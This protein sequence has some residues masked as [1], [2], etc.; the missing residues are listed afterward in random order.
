MMGHGNVKW[1]RDIN[2][3]VIEE[4]VKSS[5]IQGGLS[6]GGCKNDWINFWGFWNFLQSAYYFNDH[7][8]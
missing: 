8:W 5:S 2:N 7:I 3:S 1:W 6:K 4:G